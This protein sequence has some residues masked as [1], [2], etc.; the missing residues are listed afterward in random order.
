MDD[1]I[2]ENLPFRIS[3]PVN[4][5]DHSFQTVLRQRELGLKN[6]CGTEDF[7]FSKLYTSFDKFEIPQTPRPLQCEERR[8]YG[9]IFNLEFSLDGRLLVAACEEKSFL[10]YDASNQRCI[11]TITEA[12][13]NCVNCVRFLDTYSFATCSDD[14]SIKLWDLRNLRK[15]TK[16]LYGHSNWVKN[17]E[18]SEP[19]GTMVTSAFDGSIYTWDLKGKTRI[20]DFIMLY[21]FLVVL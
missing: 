17:I 6:K 13:T 18:F 11:K 14:M 12:H 15:E 5:N 4:N 7:I 1:E 3:H 19:E 9:G 10:L 2:C 20:I 8:K 21:S 16:V